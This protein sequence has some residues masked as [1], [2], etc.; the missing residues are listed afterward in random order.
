M[1]QETMSTIAKSVLEVV[2][3]V[4]NNTNGTKQTYTIREGQTLKDLVYVNGG[5]EETISGIVKVIRQPSQ[6]TVLP[7]MIPTS[8]LSKF[9]LSEVLQLMIRLNRNRSQKWKSQT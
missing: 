6:S 9:L 2:L 5:V 4:T 1:V 8:V 7:C 3:T